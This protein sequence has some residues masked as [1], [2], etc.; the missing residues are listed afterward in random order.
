MTMA[1]STPW[2]MSDQKKRI[3]VGIMFYGTPSHGG[4]HVSAKKNELIPSYFRSKDGWYEEDTEWAFVALSFPQYF[5]QQD[6]EDAALT[7]KNYWYEKYEEHFNVVLAPGES[8]D[9]D[10]KM[11]YEQHKNDWVAISAS[12]ADNHKVAVY[13]SLGG[14]RDF[15]NARVFLVPAIEYAQRGVAFVIDLDKHQENKII[16]VD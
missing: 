3:A 5:S 6:S 4:F 8:R 11:F 15:E 10:E 1:T 9:K 14:I 12:N 16:T 13:A 7:V 2:G